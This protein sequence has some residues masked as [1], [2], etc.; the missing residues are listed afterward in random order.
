MAR[1]DAPPAYVPGSGAAAPG[2]WREMITPEG[3]DLR[4]RIGLASERAA[5]FLLDM[6]FLSLG[7]LAFLISSCAAMSAAAGLKAEFASEAMV[8]IFVIV[9]FSVRIVYFIAFELGARAATPGKRLMGLR[10]ATRDGGR[11]TA[12]AVFARNFLREFEVF[13]PFLVLLGAKNAE[14][15]DSLLYLL[16]II[17]FGIFVFFPLF[18]RDRLRVGDLIAGTWVVKAPKRRLDV[19]LAEGSERERSGYGFTREQLDAY[20]IHELH[21]LE[22]VLRRRDTKTMAA[23]AERIRRK[24]GWVPQGPEYDAE[25]LNAYYVAL[26]GRLEGRLLMGRRRKDKYDKD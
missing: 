1:N 20:G 19:D 16:A 21:V 23:V 26:R 9:F 25:F 6:V 3:V 24:I 14:G 2:Q 8:T 10:V 12:D 13:T 22:D 17:W 5:A 4:L 18:N 15:V 11:L 7:M